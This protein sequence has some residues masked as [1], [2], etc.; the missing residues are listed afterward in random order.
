V[1]DG[2]A[3]ELRKRAGV[4]VKVFGTLVL[5]HVAG[6]RA[7]D[8]DHAG[9]VGA[10]QQSAWARRVGVQTFDEGVQAV[11]D[12]VVQLGDTLA[13]CGGDDDGVLFR[14]KVVGEVLGQDVVSGGRGVVESCKAV[15]LP[16][17]G[18]EVDESFRDFGVF[19]VLGSASRGEGRESLDATVEGARVDGIDRWVGGEEVLGQLLGLCDSIAGECRI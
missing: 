17:T 16:Q 7:A 2:L 19:A 15:E 3:G 13:L 1:C 8:G 11:G 6:Q 14:G 5:G 10:D 12:A 9:G 4:A 18:F